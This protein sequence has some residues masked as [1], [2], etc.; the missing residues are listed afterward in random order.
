MLNSVSESAYFKSYISKNILVNILYTY[1][2]FL[3]MSTQIFT[4]LLALIISI[5]PSDFINFFWP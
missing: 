1:R 3:S 2:Q 5:F 4:F